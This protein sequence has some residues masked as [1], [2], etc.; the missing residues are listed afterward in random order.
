MLFRGWDPGIPGDSRTRSSVYRKDTIIRIWITKG[1]LEKKVN[2]RFARVYSGQDWQDSGFTKLFERDAESRGSCTRYSRYVFV[3]QIRLIHYDEGIIGLLY[4]IFS[5]FLE[6]L[7]GFVES[8]ILIFRITDGGYCIHGLDSLRGVVGFGSQYKRGRGSIECSIVPSN[9]FLQKFNNLICFLLVLVRM[10]QSQLLGNGGEM[11]KGEGNRKR[12]KISDNSDLIKSYSKTLIGRCMNPM[13]QDVKALL[14]T[15]VVLLEFCDHFRLYNG[16]IGVGVCSGT[17][18]GIWID[19]LGQCI[20]RLAPKLVSSN[21]LQE[22]EL[23]M[24]RALG[25]SCW[26]RFDTGDCLEKFGTMVIIRMLN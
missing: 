4:L 2:W 23:E 8:G 16:N 11:K 20:M 17:W 13:E 3:N 12:L 10:T 7:A 14:V 15:G 18:L 21:Q 6:S 26:F 5:G 1:I 9:L 25:R 22:A 24:N 19:W